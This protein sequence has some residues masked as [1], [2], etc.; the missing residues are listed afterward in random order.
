V[1]LFNRTKNCSVEQEG[2]DLWVR[3]ALVDTVHEMA[4]EIR[5][6]LHDLEIKEIK[7]S[8]IRTPHPICKRVAEKAKNLTGLQIGKGMTRIVMETIGG[9]EGCYHYAD[10]F[11][12]AVKIL[13]TG[14]YSWI[15]RNKNEEERNK[16]YWSELRNTC[17][18]YTYGNKSNQGE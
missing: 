18:Y 1:I 8:M 12:E 14:R 16:E 9:P 11:M 5:A 13:K 7:A 3:A 6:G 17:Y 4:F 15:Y 10:L 2:E